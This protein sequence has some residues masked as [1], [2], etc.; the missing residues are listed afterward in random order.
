MSDLVLETAPLSPSGGSAVAAPLNILMSSALHMLSDPTGA[1]AES[2]R[3]LRT[4]L[5]AQ[6]LSDG[7]RSL[8]VCGTAP[9]DGSSYIASNLAVAIAQTGIRTLLIDGNMRDPGI[10]RVCIPSRPLEGLAQCLAN[11]E[12]LAQELIVESG[13]PNL[14][15]LYAGGQTPEAQEL[16]GGP[17]FKAFMS[18]CIRDYELTIIDTPAA[19][20][21]ADSRRIASVI[22]YALVVSR[23][24]HSYVKDVRTL[25][26]ELQG[27]RVSVIGSYLNDY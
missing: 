22:R 16:L 11:S 5:V 18:S 6:H 27:D 12:R 15:V 8:A 17:A 4:Y 25:I 10:D 26:A 2:I 21:C 9:G 1:Q 19:N 24:N 23:R 3:V 20:L 13:V 14:S 7:R